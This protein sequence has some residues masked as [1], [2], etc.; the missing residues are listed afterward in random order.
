[1]IKH[2]NNYFYYYDELWF[3]YRNPNDVILPFQLMERYAKKKLKNGTIFI[4]MLVII[5]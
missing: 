4:H 5:N 3:K 2:K 1:M